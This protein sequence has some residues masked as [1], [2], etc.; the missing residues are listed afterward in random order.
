MKKLLFI[1]LGITLGIMI[2]RGDADPYSWRKTV[3]LSG[4]TNPTKMR[5]DGRYLF[6]IDEANPGKIAIIDKDAALHA[7]SSVGNAYTIGGVSGSGSYHFNNTGTSLGIEGNDIPNFYTLDRDDNNGEKLRVK[8]FAYTANMLA[9]S[10]SNLS[11]PSILGDCY[12][13]QNTFGYQDD[14]SDKN[15]KGHHLNYVD[16]IQTKGYG[17]WVSGSSKYVLGWR[18]ISGRYDQMK[19]FFSS[20]IAVVEEQVGI[21]EIRD[22][23]GYKFIKL[24]FGPAQ[25]LVDINDRFVATKTKIYVLDYSSGYGNTRIASTWTGLPGEGNFGSIGAITVSGN[26]LY[27]VDNGKQKVYKTALNGTIEEHI[28]L[29]SASGMNTIN[30]SGLVVDKLDNN[31]IYLL[32]PGSKTIMVY[33]NDNAPAQPNINAGIYINNP[34]SMNQLGA[35]TIPISWSSSGVE[36][37]RIDYSLDQVNWIEIARS[38]PASQHLYNWTYSVTQPKLVYIKISDVNNSGTFSKVG[39]YPLVRQAASTTTTLSSTVNVTVTVKVNGVAASG[40]RVKVQ[41]VPRKGELSTAPIYKVTDRSGRATFSLKP[42][43]EIQ[44]VATVLAF[45]KVLSSQPAPVVYKT[46]TSGTGALELKIT[47]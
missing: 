15:A 43:R 31:T 4:T 1:V 25:E 36:N 13:G 9:T 39:F 40:A 44:A 26:K 33:R 6:I 17:L 14:G 37:V 45:R 5:I 3:S 18:K 24:D 20:S 12:R 41:L 8:H 27:I 28:N 21:W 35:A 30:I 7:S 47:K 16:L 11:S 38:V 29:T 10:P 32:Q 46:P 2:G 22:G 42:G 23:V 19:E 34:G